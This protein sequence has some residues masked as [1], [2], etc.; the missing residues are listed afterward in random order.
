MVDKGSTVDIL[1]YN[2]FVKIGLKDSDL[3]PVTTSLHNLTGDF[4]MSRGRII[5]PFTVGECPR[6]LTIMAKFL[7]VD[8][9]S[10][11]NTLLD[12][13]SLKALNFNTLIYHLTMNFLTL[14]RLGS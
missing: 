5:L 2:A 1:Y 4:I 10:A 3:K 9:P 6:T 11:F 14:E 13:P 7:V 8:C 12:R